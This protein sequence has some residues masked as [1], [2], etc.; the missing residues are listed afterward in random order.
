MVEDSSDTKGVAPPDTWDVDAVE[1]W[2]TELATSVTGGE[3]L[4]VVSLFDQGF[5]RCVSP[6]PSAFTDSGV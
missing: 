6:L 5:D 3:T 4:S 2:L 1:Q